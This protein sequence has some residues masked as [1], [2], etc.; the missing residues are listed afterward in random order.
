MA[1][2]L[3]RWRLAT[4]ALEHCPTLD[5][6]GCIAPALGKTNTNPVDDRNVKTLSIKLGR[7]TRICN[8]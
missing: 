3:M 8:F 6:L 2:L 5:P 4:R 1:A 7:T